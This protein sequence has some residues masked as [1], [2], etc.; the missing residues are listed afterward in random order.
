ML[1]AKGSTK[2]VR[3]YYR[4]LNRQLDD[5]ISGI[6]DNELRGRDPLHGKGKIQA[7]RLLLLKYNVSLLE[8]P[9]CRDAE[10]FDLFMYSHSYSFADLSTTNPL[11]IHSLNRYIAKIDT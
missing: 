7:R 9:E 10:Y 6:N 5:Q 3:L 4:H 1:L 11:P 2:N 8:T